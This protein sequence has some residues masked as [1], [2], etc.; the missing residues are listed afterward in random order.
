MRSV[1]IYGGKECILLDQ[2]SSIPGWELK[3][4]EIPGGHEYCLSR[5]NERIALCII[6]SNVISTSNVFPYDREHNQDKANEILNELSN[7]LTA[8]G[9]PNNVSAS[10]DDLT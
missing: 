4:L 2:L 1:L 6:T 8:A 5:G 7:A 10:D 9:I 3:P